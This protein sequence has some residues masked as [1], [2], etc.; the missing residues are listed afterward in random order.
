MSGPPVTAWWYSAYR[1]LVHYSV[2]T[3]PLWRYNIVNF[4]VLMRTVF[5]DVLTVR[6]VLGEKVLKFEFTLKCAEA[7]DIIQWH[8]LRPRIFPHLSAYCFISCEPP[9]TAYVN[10]S[11]E[12]YQVDVTTNTSVKRTARWLQAI[13]KYSGE[14]QNSWR[15]PWG[16]LR[17]LYYGSDMGLLL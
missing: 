5:H 3:H 12:C 2:C 9:P 11:S 13:R 15:V 8:C 7:V 17:W 4:R 6:W 10:Q 14:K 16:F 1:C